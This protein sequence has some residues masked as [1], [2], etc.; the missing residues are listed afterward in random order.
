MSMKQDMQLLEKA[1]KWGISERLKRSCIDTL[2]QIIEHDGCFTKD[3]IAAV[4]TV[5]KIAAL[6]L[7]ERR[8]EE[9]SK[10]Q[11]ETQGTL[12]FVLPPNGTEANKH[13]PSPQSTAGSNHRDQ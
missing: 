12:V 8:M 7:Q 3:R 4:D 6:E 2:Q 5:V 13:L 11:V 9:E 10:E 1:S